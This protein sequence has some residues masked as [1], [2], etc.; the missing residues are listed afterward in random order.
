VLTANGRLGERPKAEVTLLPLLKRNLDG[1]RHAAM[2]LAEPS[3]S[4]TWLR[5]DVG[6]AAFSER[7]AD[8]PEG[9]ELRHDTLAQLVTW[10]SKREGNVCVEALELTANADAGNSQ[11][12]RGAA[13]D[14]RVRRSRQLLTPAALLTVG[15]PQAPGEPSVVSH[16]FA[17]TLDPARRL[18]PRNGRDEMRAGEVEAGRK[19]R[20]VVVIRPL[21]GYRG[22]SER[23]ANG[24][25]EKRSRLP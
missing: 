19:G 8:G 15:S 21:L 5:S 18:K 22:R 6:A 2:I 17:P 12:Q 16:R 10:L 1:D 9:L 4:A 7:A 25:A 11:P 14:E 13:V 20:A 24:G 23:A 3:R